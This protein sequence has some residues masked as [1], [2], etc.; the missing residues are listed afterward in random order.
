MALI[1]AGERD[2]SMFWFGLGSS[3]GLG[4]CVV[5][6]LGKQGLAECLFLTKTLKTCEHKAWTW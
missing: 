5:V 3:L 1:S 4:F 2:A 6:G